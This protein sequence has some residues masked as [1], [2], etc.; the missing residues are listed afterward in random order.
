VSLELNYFSTDSP[1]SED[2]DEIVLRN[3]VESDAGW[4]GDSGY[5]QRAVGELTIK[6]GSVTEYD[7]V[8]YHLQSLYGSGAPMWLVH[9][10]DQ[11]DRALLV[12]RPQGQ[13]GFGFSR[14]W[15]WRQGT[16]AYREHEPRLP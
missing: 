6:L 12:R 9:D 13:L 4:A 11:G 14:G 10:A 15:G 2:H 8:R 16:L 1:V 3:Q 5:T 7:L